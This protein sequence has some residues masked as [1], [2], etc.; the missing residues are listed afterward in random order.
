MPGFDGTGPMGL[1]PMTGGGRGYC[2]VS[3]PQSSPAFMAGIAYGPHAGRWVAPY[4]R[5]AP[6][7]TAEEELNFLRDQAQVLK[8]HLGRI[9]ARIRSLTSKNK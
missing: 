8:E 6:S 7:V 4:F 9:D 2:A 1:G 3:L 5:I